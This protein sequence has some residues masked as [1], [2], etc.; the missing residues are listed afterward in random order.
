MSTLGAALENGDE[1]FSYIDCLHWLDLSFLWE[2]RWRRGEAE[3]LGVAFT[4]HSRKAEWIPDL[5]FVISPTQIHTLH[6]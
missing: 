4:S 1:S 5:M 3:Q 6:C 2:D